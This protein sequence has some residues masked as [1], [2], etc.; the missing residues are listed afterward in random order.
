MVVLGCQHS[1]PEEIRVTEWGP[2]YNEI[3][4]IPKT[5][6]QILDISG[7]EA[8][9]ETK[10]VH[11]APH[12]NG[13]GG[14]QDHA[15]I[16][17]EGVR[18][19]ISLPQYPP[20]MIGEDSWFDIYIRNPDTYDY[21]DDVSLTFFYDEDLYLRSVTLNGP[22][23][24]GRY[25]K[26]LFIKGQSDQAAKLSAREVSSEMRRIIKDDSRNYWGTMP[27]LVE[28]LIL[29]IDNHIKRNQID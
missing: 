18:Y 11:N 3:K 17:F 8:L 29:A 23:F 13:F 12:W 14:D 19:A 15:I 27:S 24:T 6:P 21:E 22:R 16:L 1:P 5:P 26:Q 20:T 10:F 28:K 25:T 7:L 2:D 9:W 4:E